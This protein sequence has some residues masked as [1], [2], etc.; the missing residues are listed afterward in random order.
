LLDLTEVSHS[1]GYPATGTRNYQIIPER[2]L[3]ESAVPVFKAWTRPD[4]KLGQ[5]NRRL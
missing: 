5:V 4:R 3:P 2:T 1:C